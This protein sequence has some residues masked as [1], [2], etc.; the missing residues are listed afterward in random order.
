MDFGGI[1]K[2]IVQN[3]EDLRL[4]RQAQAGLIPDANLDTQRIIAQ[5]VRRHF[6]QR[7]AVQITTP[8]PP[9][10]E[11]LQR[12]SAAQNEPADIYHDETTTLDAERQPSLPGPTDHGAVISREIR[13]GPVARHDLLCLRHGYVT[14]VDD[15]FAEGVYSADIR[16]VV[17]DVNGSTVTVRWDYEL[18]SMYCPIQIQVPP[19]NVPEITPSGLAA[20]DDERF[21]TIYDWPEDR[22][23]FKTIFGCVMNFVRELVRAITWLVT[24]RP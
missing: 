14:K 12:L 18:A 15:P 8:T 9:H 20:L 4:Y 24:G 19:T 21:A 6:D 7:R 5:D 23:V 17:E 1:K 2:R 13:N 11:F 10:P 16:G 22:N 3:I